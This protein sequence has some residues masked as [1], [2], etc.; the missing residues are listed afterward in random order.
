MPV[1]EGLVVS[2]SR[3]TGCARSSPAR[4]HLHRRR[5]V[6]ARF[7]TDCR[8]GGQCRARARPAQADRAAIHGTALGG[9][10]E[11]ALV[12]HARIIAPD[13]Y[14]GFPEV[15]IGLIPGAGGT[16]RTPRL[17]GPLV[18]LDMVTSGR[19]VPA[20]E[21]M[22][23]GLVDEVATDSSHAA[24]L[25]ESHLA[26]AGLLRGV[27]ESGIPAYERARFGGG[28]RGAPQGAGAPAPCAR[29]RGRRSR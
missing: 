16:Q 22:A 8:A 9:G 1:R 26:G 23:L 5:G 7:I 15:R 6:S 4:T 18:A 12:C 14:V 13:G 11:L 21:A 10:Y 25:R 20:D 17:A 27:G 28:G 29:R 19:S 24:I 2:R 3:A